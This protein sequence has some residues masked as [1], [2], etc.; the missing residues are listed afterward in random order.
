MSKK[1]PS[2]MKITQ[3][4][5]PSETLNILFNGEGMDPSLVNGIRRTII[6]ESPC[7]SLHGK[8]TIHVNTSDLNDEYL[9]TRVSM[10]P[11][12][13][14][15][16]DDTS[17]YDDDK[18]RFWICAKGDNKKPLLN[19]GDVDL[20]VTAHMIQI[21]DKSG[22]LVDIKAEELIKYNFPLLKLRKGREFHLEVEAS[23][24]IG[25]HHA[26]YKSGIVTYKFENPV[27][28]GS[29]EVNKRNPITNE[30]V[31]TLED[32]QGYMKNELGNPLNISMTI[33][34]NGHYKVADILKLGISTLE[35]KFHQLQMLLDNRTKGISGETTIEIIPST[36]IEN[37][38][39]IKIIDSDHTMTPLATHTIGN[40]V[41]C[42]MN[43]R[44]E[45]LVKR[46]M[47][48]IRQAMASYSRPHPLD[49]II[50]LNIR[51][52]DNLYGKDYKGNASER[53]LDE[54]IGDILNNLR[55]LSGN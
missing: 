44:I 7:Y 39:R 55:Q 2:P 27:S 13:V 42:H 51:A 12:Y 17:L 1:S 29:K 9:M 38:V 45:R 20:E 47:E 6:G 40:L 10:V 53:L 30:K 31:E 21:F 18:I 8:F 49:E 26:T 34:A 48:R 36:D 33:R 22:N 54:T 28:S 35:K 32:K 16:L 15:N 46:D 4:N 11:L 41:A 25:R 19:E 24:N 23:K 3:I 43:Y 14:D 52:P 5:G 37:Y 50:Y